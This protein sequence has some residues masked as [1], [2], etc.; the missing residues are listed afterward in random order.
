M[1]KTA[2]RRKSQATII[3]VAARA[4]VSI[5]TV[6][7]VLNGTAF[8]EEEK[9]LRVEAAI[10]ELGFAPRAAARALA[11]RRTKTIG[12]LVP[13]ISGDFFVPMLRGVEGAANEAGYELLIQ[14][15]RFDRGPARRRVL[16]EQNTDGLLLFADSVD[17]ASLIELA[18][19]DFPLVLLY[20]DAPAGLELPSVTVENEAG[21]AEAVGHL[22][23][24]HKRRR[25]VCLTGPEGNHDAEARLAGYRLA[26]AQR[27]LAFDPELLAPGDFSGPRAAASIQGLIA[28]GV[29]FDAIFAGD[30]GAAL[31]VLGALSEAGVEVGRDVS[32]IGF[33]DLAFARLSRPPLATVKAPTEEVGSESVRLLIDRIEGRDARS[34][35]LPTTF[36]PRSSCGCG[37][38]RGPGESER[39]RAREG[40]ASK[41]A[42]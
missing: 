29:A 39:P 15:T 21:A 41:E 33:D 2:P 11:G 16:G 31:G 14:T 12:L 27:G 25:I 22:A 24:A 10:A 38:G 40:E 26:L 32:V 34:L 42:L 18:E 13:E 17:G 9:K 3:D 6:S 4:Q 1:P 35:I 5:S 36:L 20:T 8:V 23:D 37:H 7:R 19:K 30:D 28:R